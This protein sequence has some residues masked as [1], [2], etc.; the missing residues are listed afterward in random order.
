MIQEPQI[1]PAGSLRTC[2][3]SVPPVLLVILKMLAFLFLMLCQM[4]DS[5][6]IF[7]V[8][9]YGCCRGLSPVVLFVV[10]LTFAPFGEKLSAESPF[11]VG[12]T[13]QVWFVDGSGSNVFG[14]RF[15]MALPFSEGFAAVRENGRYKF[16]DESGS[17]IS[18]YEYTYASSFRDGYA[19]VS[20][21]GLRGAINRF[22]AATLE[23][24]Y[25]VLD[26]LGGGLFAFEKDRKYGVV[27]GVGEVLLKPAFSSITSIQ[28][29]V[30]VVCS[31][32]VYGAIN[33]TGSQILSFE[34]V[35]L[36]NI[37]DGL[38]VARMRNGMVVYLK[39]DGGKAFDRTFVSARGFVGDTALA[40][41]G[42][43]KWSVIGRDGKTI[44]RTRYD[45]VGPQELRCF[46]VK[47][48]SKWGVSTSDGK[49]LVPAIYDRVSVGVGYGRVWV[50]DGG[51][52]GY[53]STN[54]NV[55]LRL[56]VWK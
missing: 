10:A 45:D 19:L 51:R 18:P 43:G 39:P 17:Y 48:G 34:Y 6:I 9:K 55:L 56:R 49:L 20:S 35:Q 1:A 31:N 40:W 41:D 16:V 53:V 21:N 44:A 3:Q 37:S 29:G 36:S 14:K 5:I 13:N 30:C 54:G 27:N 2:P 47:V 23:L 38:F 26:D 4:A 46:S 7:R 28:D 25:R 52:L 32:F 15:Q 12:N 11:L 24:S 8:N 42:T 33:L 50:F 22:G